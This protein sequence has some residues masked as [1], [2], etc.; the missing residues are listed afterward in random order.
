MAG[1]G[2]T[3]GLE[4]SDM[5]KTLLSVTVNVIDQVISIRN[6]KYLGRTGF[7]Y[8]YLAAL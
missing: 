6:A 1:H 2:V 5:Y 4:Y 8:N 3:L 7:S